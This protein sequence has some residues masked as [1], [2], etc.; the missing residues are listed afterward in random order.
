MKKKFITFLLAASMVLTG[1]SGCAGD[2][3]AEKND[4]AAT[5]NDT[6]DTADSQAAANTE[7]TENGEKIKVVCTIFP[8]YDWVRQITGDNV[9]LSLL[10]DSGTD[11][12]S[13]QATT[14]DIAAISSC[15]LLVYTGGE[16]DRWVEDAL[17]NAVNENMKVI[18]LMD[19]LGDNVKA[20]EIK[21]GM[22][23]DHD[24]DHDHE[25]EAE[26]HDHEHEEELDEHVWLSL[27]N[28]K[29]CVTAIAAALA[30]ADSVNADTYN[31]NAEAYNGEID[32]L[33]KEYTEMVSAAS[34]KTIIFGDRFPFRYLT[35]DYGLDYYAAFSGCSAETEASFETIVF[36][37]NKFDELK[38]KDIFI[39]DNSDG[40]IAQTV[41]ENTADKDQEIL[42]LDSMQSVNAA[43]IEAGTTYLSVMRSNLEVLGEALSK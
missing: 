31:T 23:H 38:L 12:H 30:E 4:T 40:S 20:E 36:L 29:T 3:G 26:E 19:V 32:A 16:S 25:E 5:Q 7:Q 28:A 1:L 18:K 27:K 13:Y 37:A 17:A 14:E 42:T 33:D 8:Q 6:T 22:E 15:D 43:D 11:L 41:V 10:L 21:E 9:E 35:D 34:V 2:S 24:H 39:I